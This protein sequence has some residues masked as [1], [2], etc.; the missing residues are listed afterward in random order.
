MA[1]DEGAPEN[2]A[3]QGSMD[4]LVGALVSPR[5]TFASIAARPSWLWPLVLLIVLNVALTYS[6]GRRVGWRGFIEKQFARSTR[7]AALSPNQRAQALDR[8]VRTAPM[9]G[10][11][12]GTIGTVI[13]LAVIAGI[14]V[15]AFNIIFGT[16]IRFGAS[17]GIAAHA[18]LPEVVRGLLGIV[19]VLTKPPEGVDL[20]NLV[21]SNVGVFLPIDAAQWLRVLAGSLDVFAFWTLALLAIGYSAAG[22]SRKV[23]FGSALAVVIV[24]WLVYLAGAVGVTAMFTT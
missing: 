12:G 3:Q 4:R 11:G 16:S 15:G 1:N 23:S 8:A 21:A 24:L 6:Y 13:V 7:I 10:Y 9:F 14:F 5:A 17:F 18:F 2:S 20:Q 19:I 22:S